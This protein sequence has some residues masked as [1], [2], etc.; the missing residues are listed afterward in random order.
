MSQVIRNAIAHEYLEK[1]KHHVFGLADRHISSG[2]S[3]KYEGE[4]LDA[5]DFVGLLLPTM[6]AIVNGLLITLSEAKRED[7][8]FYFKIP[9]LRRPG[10]LPFYMEVSTFRRQIPLSKLRPLLDEVFDVFVFPD[11]KDLDQLIFNTFSKIL[12]I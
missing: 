1:I 3:L 10:E 11:H 4:A 8:P 2:G 12:P 7:L 6:M 5:D 9:N